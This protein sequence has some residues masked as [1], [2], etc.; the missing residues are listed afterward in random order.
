M[1][2]LSW[3]NW[4]PSRAIIESGFKYIQAPRPELYDLQTDPGETANIYEQNRGKAAAMARRLKTMRQ[5]Y[6]DNYLASQSAQRISDNTKE[7]L[8]SLGYVFSGNNSRVEI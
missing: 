2:R 8:A 7:K 1:L 5:E 3:M 4:S 6:S